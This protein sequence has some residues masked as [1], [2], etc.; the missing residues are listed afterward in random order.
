MNNKEKTE[1]K[2]FIEVIKPHQLKYNME[3]NKMDL[4]DLTLNDIKKLLY[5][6]KPIA[7]K[8]GKSPEGH[9][10]ITDIYGQI[11]NFFI[12]EAEMY[13]EEGKEVIKDKE[14]AQLLIRWLVFKEK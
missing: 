7:Y 14:P 13:N 1:N 12:P 9:Y 11:I 6:H 5:K 2:S 4:E 3:V 8:V 10:Y